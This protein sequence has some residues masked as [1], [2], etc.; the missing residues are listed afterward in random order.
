MRRALLVLV[1]VVVVGVM[2][3]CAD[4]DPDGTQVPNPAA[5]HCEERGGTVS[6]P[7]PMCTLP[8]GSVVDAWELYREASP[9][10]TG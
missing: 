10:P 8:D 5:A 4:G 7:E 6:G 3:G 1:P 9:E 2:G